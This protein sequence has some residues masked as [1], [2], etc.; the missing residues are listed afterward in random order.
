[1]ANYIIN[2]KPSDVG[3]EQPFADDVYLPLSLRQEHCE[4]RRA[5]PSNVRGETYAR[6]TW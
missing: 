4:W 1:M 6:G 3:P 5:V 2:L